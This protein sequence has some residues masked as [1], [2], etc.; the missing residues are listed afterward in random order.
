MN[1]NSACSIHERSLVD[2]LRHGASGKPRSDVS[3]LALLL[4]CDRRV[5]HYLLNQSVPAVVKL[6]PHQRRLGIDLSVACSPSNKN[7]T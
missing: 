5:P 7:T 3:S 4:H 6:S 1:D 2:S